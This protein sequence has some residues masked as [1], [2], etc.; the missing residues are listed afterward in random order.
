MTVPVKLAGLLTC[1]GPGVLPDVA[2]AGFAYHL[3][4]HV[5]YPLLHA[6]MDVHVLCIFRTGQGSLNTDRA[7]LGVSL[8][9][10]CFQQLSI[11]LRPF[12]KGRPLVNALG[13][14]T[15]LVIVG[16]AL[17]VCKHVGQLRSCSH[18][19]GVKRLGIVRSATHT[20]DATAATLVWL[21][22]RGPCTHSAMSAADGEHPSVPFINA[23]GCYRIS[24]CLKY[25]WRLQGY[26]GL[27][28]RTAYPRGREG[29]PSAH[30]SSHGTCIVISHDSQNASRCH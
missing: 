21:L 24:L 7:R 2:N 19:D 4:H 23:S 3:R 22:P 26:S 13:G 11:L 8:W 29:L 30:Q 28:L 18:T 20:A 16:E 25:R 14:L 1:V 15:H 6:L 17:V 5:K 27:C 12:R 10:L 9:N